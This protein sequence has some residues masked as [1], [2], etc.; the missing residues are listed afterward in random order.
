[1]KKLAFSALLASVV[2]SNS[3]WSE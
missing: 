3:A 2:F 1:M